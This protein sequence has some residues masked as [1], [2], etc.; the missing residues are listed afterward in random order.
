MN[1]AN[2]KSGIELITSFFKELSN[3]RGKYPDSETIEAILQLYKED[4]L[5][6]S[7]IT[8][9]LQEIREKK[10]IDVTKN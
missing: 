10:I 6:P 3:K 9:L 2:P 8:N 4:K 1:N 5:T 7:K